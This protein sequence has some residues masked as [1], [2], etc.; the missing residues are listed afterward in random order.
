M[1][2]KLTLCG[3]ICTDR[4]CPYTCCTL[5]MDNGYVFYRIYIILCIDNKSPL[6]YVVSYLHVV[7]FEHNI[8]F[9]SSLYFVSSELREVP[10][11]TKDKS[12]V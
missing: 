2:H 9:Y 1:M 4:N 3:I 8:R 11:D 12:I 7:I 5:P 6:T 10:S